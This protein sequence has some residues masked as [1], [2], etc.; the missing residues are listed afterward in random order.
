MSGKAAFQKFT[1]VSYW[2]IIAIE[3]TVFTCTHTIHLEENYPKKKMFLIKA[4]HAHTTYIPHMGS[5]NKTMPTVTKIQQ[6]RKKQ[7]KINV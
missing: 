2:N 6:K 1:F 5:K 7:K 3:A 4:T